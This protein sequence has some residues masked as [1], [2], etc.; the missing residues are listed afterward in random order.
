[1]FNFTKKSLNYFFFAYYKKYTYLRVHF[2]PQIMFKNNFFV[3][4]N[5]FLNCF[6]R[7]DFKTFLKI[8]YYSYFSNL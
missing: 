1:M 5:M 3:C 8:L 6:L 2:L 4:K 7:H